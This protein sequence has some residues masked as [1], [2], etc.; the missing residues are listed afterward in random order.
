MRPA[1]RSVVAVLLLGVLLAGCGSSGD[2][3]ATATTVGKA[4]TTTKASTGS[5][6]GSSGT[7]GDYFP[8]AVGDTWVYRLSGSVSDTATEKVTAVD[9]QS[10]GSTVVSMS[11]HSQAHPNFDHVLEYVLHS[12][13]RLG[14]LPQTITFA[15]GRQLQAGYHA[16]TYP[17]LDDL[18]AGRAA[19]GTLIEPLGKSTTDTISLPWT[20]QGGGMAKVTVPFGTF[21]TLVVRE[22]LGPDA[23]FGTT[24]YAKGVGGVKVET[25]G[26]L[27]ELISFTAAKR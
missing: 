22:S 18:R 10:D 1:W 24:Y 7:F 25:Q 11:Y 2:K 9:R 6:S 23:T 15:N 21:D 4:T 17:S 16:V 12:D 26:S 14:I 19:S 3:E 13:G 20:V 8:H 27:T 5:G